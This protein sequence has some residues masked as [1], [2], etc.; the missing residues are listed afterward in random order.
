M[1][2]KPSTEQIKVRKWLAIRKRAG[3]KIDPETAEV[4][5]SYGQILNP[6]GIEEVPKDCQQ[7][8]RCYFA[9]SRGSDIW[10]SFYDLPKATE[11]A[12]WKKIRAGG[13]D[14]DDPDEQLGEDLPY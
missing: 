7:G 13:F 9:R 5:C 10:V 4:E 8:G 12:L 11:D 3:R 2:T 14:D 1:K 6:Y